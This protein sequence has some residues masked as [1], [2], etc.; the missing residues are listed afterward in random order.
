MILSEQTEMSLPF[1]QRTAL[2]HAVAFLS[3]CL[4]FLW[5]RDDGGMP[6]SKG[7]LKCD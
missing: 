4:S 6:L 3:S 7:A 5:F 2:T 1:H